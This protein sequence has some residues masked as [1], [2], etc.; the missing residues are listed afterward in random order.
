M[1]ALAAIAMLV[2]GV[3]GAT[4]A[5]A[6][7]IR[8]GG[9]AGGHSYYSGYAVI[10]GPAAPVIVFGYEPGVTIRAYWLP[11]WRNRHYFPFHGD[12][13]KRRATSSYHGRPKP[14]ETYWRYWSNDGAYLHEL[15]PAILRSYDRAPAP[16]GPNHSTLVR[17]R[18]NATLPRPDPRSAVTVKQEY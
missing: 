13:K 16:R 8:T 17:P 4:T 12:L 5:G 3:A 10:G 9:G 1:R 15:P 6:A 7:D 18:Y 11:P 14:A 2:F